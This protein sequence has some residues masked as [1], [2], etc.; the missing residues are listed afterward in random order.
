MHSPPWASLPFACPRGG[1]GVPGCGERPAQVP[2]VHEGP[3][4]LVLAAAV[5]LTERTEQDASPVGGTPCAP[6]ASLAP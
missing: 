6:T 5:T 3:H 2:P 1:R 4:V